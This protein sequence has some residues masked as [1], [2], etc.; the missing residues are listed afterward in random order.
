VGISSPGEN[1]DSSFEATLTGPAGEFSVRVPRDGG[2]VLTAHHRRWGS[3]VSRRSPDLD[4]SAAP[5][6]I[7]LEPRD[8]SAQG[9]LK[10]ELGQ[11]I[12]GGR[13]DLQ[14]DGS[15]DGEAFAVATDEEGRFELRLP[16]GSYDVVARAG[17]QATEAVSFTLPLR[18]PLELRLFRNGPSAEPPSA[19]EL[20]FVQKHRRPLGDKVVVWTEDWLRDVQVVGLGEQTHGA[21]EA[22]VA[23]F[24]LAK[25]L[26]VDHGFNVVALEAGYEAAWKLGEWVRGKPGNVRQ[27]VDT[28][29]MWIWHT[30]EMVEFATWL[31]EENGRRGAANAIELWGV[32][33]Y[34]YFP[35]KLQA[36]RD[37]L[38]AS[39]FVA[40][41]E[42]L[43][44]VPS[45]RSC[46]ELEPGFASRQ[47]W[48][49]V[50][51]ADPVI[52]LMIDSI[53]TCDVLASGA[54]P[55]VGERFAADTSLRILAMRAGAAGRQRKD[56]AAGAR[57]S[58]GSRARR[59]VAGRHPGPVSVS[60]VGIPVPSR[61]RYHRHG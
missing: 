29:G 7:L 32:Y 56:G 34:S 60:L 26:I 52:A 43:K 25:S 15:R 42:L 57:Q 48:A 21:R 45:V 37:R 61:R 1:G 18:E 9:V 4:G 31:R 28:L 54:T 16:D 35:T 6:D 30:Q 50:R 36:L 58:R 13:I 3:V 44:E 47:R 46:A 10:D 59:Q 8:V 22:I 27:A 33:G 38:A 14:V 20:A 24:D 11:P 39:Q 41:S 19:Q 2:Y 53:R 40:R 17:E 55:D 5:I 12:A 23:R 51:Q 49:R